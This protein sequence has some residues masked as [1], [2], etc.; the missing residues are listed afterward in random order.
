MM[1]IKNSDLIK[2]NNPNK[3]KCIVVDDEPLAR[4]GMHRLIAKEKGLELLSSFNNALDAI[5]YLHQTEVDLVFLD[6]RMPGTS[7]LEFAGSISGKTLVIFT[8]AYEQYAIKS[9]DLDAVDYLLKPIQQERFEKAV[10]KAALMHELLQSKEAPSELG[11]STEDYLFIKAER[12]F[13]KVYYNDICYVE[14]LKD[15]VILHIGEEKLI[16]AVNLKGMHSRLPERLFMRVGK[17]YLVN[18]SRIT[19]F[20]LHTLY[21]GTKEVPLGEAYRKAFFSNFAKKEI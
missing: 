5:S 14:G 3:M 1:N 21:L 6:I 8:T 9:Y 13:Y 7:G 4:E 12:R 10:Q 17:S 2:E 19:S 11:D 15:Y 18:T 16:T 20:D